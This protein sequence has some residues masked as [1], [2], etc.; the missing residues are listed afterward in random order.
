MR[1]TMP[2]RRVNLAFALLLLFPPIALQSQQQPIAAPDAANATRR[3]RRS[4]QD[5]LRRPLP[6][7]TSA[8]FHSV[9]TPG[10]YIYDSGVRFDGDAIMTLLNAAHAK[11][12]KY[13]WNV[14]SPDVH[15]TGDTAWIAYVN[16]GSMTDTSGKQDLQW[17]ESAFLVKQDGKWKIAFMHSTKAAKQ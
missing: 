1:F 15:I 11:G 3:S 6:L 16:Q 10:F 17:L 14:T 12:Q 7:T 2:I 8:K 9:V 4:S 13:E 5:H